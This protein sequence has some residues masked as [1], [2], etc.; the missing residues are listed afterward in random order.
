V[1]RRRFLLTLVGGAVAGPLAAE[2]Q[3][4]AK[5]YHVGLL[6]V[7]GSPTTWRVGYRPFIEAMRDLNY[8]EGRNLIIRPAFADGKAE[9]LPALVTELLSGKVDVIVTTANR[10]TAAV[11]RASSSIPIVAWLLS[12][13]VTEGLIA[14]LARP[15]GNI[16]GL[17]GFVPGLSQKYVEL[18][19]EVVS[20]AQRFTVITSPVNPSREIRR[21]L[22]A[23]GR[24]LGVTVSVAHVTGSGPNTFDSVLARAKKDGAAGIIAT[25]DGMTFL[26]RRTLVQGALNHRLPGIYWSRD[27]VEAGGLMAYSA[28]IDDLRRRVAT[29]VDKI[30]RGAIPADLPVEQPTTFELVINLKTAKAL[31]LTIPPSLLARA[32]KVIE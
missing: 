6:S 15:G 31:G 27:Y 7:G 3:Q 4:A 13:P 20:S 29:H 23:A 32:D 22:E 25:P 12:D 2:A 11:K 19:R 1:D 17:T 14:S 16:T 18:L 24:A 8:V 10:E 5:V 28:D 26:H 21:E 30:L 9:R